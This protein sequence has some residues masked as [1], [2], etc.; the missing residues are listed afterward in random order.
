MFNQKEQ[1]YGALA[2]YDSQN[3]RISVREVANGYVISVD[4]FKCMIP[5][6]R[7][8][9]YIAKDESDVRK[10]IME[11]LTEWEGKDD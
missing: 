11:V 9:E 8:N 4:R 2:G 7:F 5:S 6:E 10:L 3:L 1:A